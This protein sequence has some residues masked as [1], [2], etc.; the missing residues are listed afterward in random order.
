LNII[1]VITEASRFCGWPWWYGI[2][3]FSWSNRFV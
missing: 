1:S 3:I 2:F